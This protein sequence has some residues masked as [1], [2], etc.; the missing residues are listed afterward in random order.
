MALVFA[1]IALVAV[2]YYNLEICGIY[3]AFMAAMACIFMFVS[4]RRAQ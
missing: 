3:V 2:I 4:S 1:V